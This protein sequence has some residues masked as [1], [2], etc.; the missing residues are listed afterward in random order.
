MAS[1]C[2]RKGRSHRKPDVVERGGAGVKIRYPKIME[3][4]QFLHAKISMTS[5]MNDP[6][7]KCCLLSVLLSVYRRDRRT[8]LVRSPQIRSQSTY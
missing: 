7:A 3:E 5:F 4:I 6:F 1:P 8:S 2:R